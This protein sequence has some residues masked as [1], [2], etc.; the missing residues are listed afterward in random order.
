MIA[1][2]NTVDP[3]AEISRRWSPYNYVENNPIKNIDPD[4]MACYG[5]RFDPNV[6]FETGQPFKDNNNDLFNP[7]DNHEPD[8][9]PQFDPPQIEDKFGPHYIGANAGGD[10]KG[11]G[12][13]K[14]DTKKDDDDPYLLRLKDGLTMQQLVQ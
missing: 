14:G 3:L 13:K 4:G 6:N 11:G 2:W 7:R 5:C 9:H 10:G 1:R 8:D 12:K